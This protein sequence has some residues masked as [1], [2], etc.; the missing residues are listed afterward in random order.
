MWKILALLLVLPLTARA[1]N[2]DGTWLV[3]QRVAFDIFQCRDDL[4]G[5]IVWLRDPR[6][7]TRENCGR[8]IIWGLTAKGPTQWDNGW[9]Y[10]PEDGKTYN[11]RAQAESSDRITARI[12]DGIP[13]FG[14]TENLSRIT[15]HSLEGWCS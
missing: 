10:D 4:C 14:R 15:S 7:R 1:D 8:T 11:V 9:F 6:L 12:Y 13:L 5:K 2:P 3:S